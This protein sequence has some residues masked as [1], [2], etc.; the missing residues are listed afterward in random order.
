LNGH[1][2]LLSLLRNTESTYD[3]YASTPTLAE[4]ELLANPGSLRSLIFFAAVWLRENSALFHLMSDQFQNVE[5]RPAPAQGAGPLPETI[6]LS[7]LNAVERLQVANVQRQLT[8]F[9]RISRQINGILSVEGVK[10][11]F[12]FEPELLLTRKRLTEVEKRLLAFQRK[13][14]ALVLYA[15][16]NLYPEMAAKMAIAASADGFLFENLTDVFDGATEQMFTDDTHLTPEANRVV[17]AR[18]AKFFT[19]TVN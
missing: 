12:L 15:F 17:A 8:F 10:S 4:F 14:P 13:D 7:D 19:N 5:Q 9:P 1:N 11:I 6:Q 16:Q 2:D 18:L 3:P